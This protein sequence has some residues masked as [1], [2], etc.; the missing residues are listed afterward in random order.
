MADSKKPSLLF[1]EKRLIKLYED[2]SDALYRYA[3]RFLSNEDLAEEC[4]S[5]V[6]TRFLQ[7]I[8]DGK[9]PNGNIR[10]Y[11]YRIAHNWVVDYYRKRKPDENIG[12]EILPD[13]VSNP[14]SDVSR[15]QSREKLRNA[16]LKL[17]EDQRMVVE[18][19][20]M[21]DWTHER[22]A[23]Y[24]GKTVE[25]SRALKYRALKNLRSALDSIG[26]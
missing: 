8:V 2:H 24:L 10:A 5:E 1:D 14:E 26:M 11:L 7:R 25:A 21:E 12:S 16:M 9:A 17:P 15:M 23:E 4:V 22:V 18:L 6:F 20:V 19:H 13:R 3:Y